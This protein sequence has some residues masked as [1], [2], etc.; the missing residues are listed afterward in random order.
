MSLGQTRFAPGIIPGTKG[1]T[2]TLCEKS[3]CAFFARY[4]TNFLSALCCLPTFLI[5]P[6]PYILVFP[7]ALIGSALSFSCL[8]KN[9]GKCP[10]KLTFASH[11]L[12]S[13][14]LAHVTHQQH[15]H[16]IKFP[17]H[18]AFILQTSCQ[19]PYLNCLHTG[20]KFTNK[21]LQRG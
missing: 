13:T 17:N 11:I 2:E 3:L 21:L 15:Y 10:H 9:Q 16:Y 18:V 19:A 5:D 6:D 20:R 4:R 1:G 7:K 14:P 12:G 8:A